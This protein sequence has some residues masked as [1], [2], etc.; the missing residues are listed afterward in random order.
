[1]KNL[2]SSKYIK[3]GEY[4]KGSENYSY[5]PKNNY[6]EKRNLIKTSWKHFENF[7]FQTKLKSR[8][9]SWNYLQYLKATTNYREI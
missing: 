2:K 6:Q 8:S 1:M 5:H 9:D 7:N 4:S 3:W